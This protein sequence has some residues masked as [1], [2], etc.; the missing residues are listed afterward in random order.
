MAEV[1]SSA[2]TLLA[3]YL[4]GLI[5][6]VIGLAVVLYGVFNSATTTML[7]GFV[8]AAVGIWLVVRKIVERNRPPA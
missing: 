3:K 2:G 8:V 7:L 4:L 5:L 1:R 6:T